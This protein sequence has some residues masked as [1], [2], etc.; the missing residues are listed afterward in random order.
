[1]SVQLAKMTDEPT[2]EQLELVARHGSG[3]FVRAL[4]TVRLLKRQ[5][6]EDDLREIIGGD[7]VEVAEV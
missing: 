7:D 3:K 6:R 2:N 1:M 4:A 5:D